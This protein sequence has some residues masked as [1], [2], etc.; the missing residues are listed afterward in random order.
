MSTSKNDG[1]S[2]GNWHLIYTKPRQE[3][4]A[5]MHLLR[6]GY[7][8][9]LPF[10]RRRQYR[11]DCYQII[12]EPMFPRYLFIHLNETTDNWGPIRSTRGVSSLVKFGGMPAKVPNDLID[13]LK[14]TENKESVPFSDSPEFKE[15]E[16]VCVLNGVMVG[17]KGIVTATSSAKRVTV[18]LDIIG[19]STRVELPVDSVGHQT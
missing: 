6:Q 14:Q 13:F 16:P 8:I 9:Y 12:I 10:V 11:Q 15:G 17:Y 3:K 2:V 1:R 5:Q 18:L 19:R 4:T 7:S